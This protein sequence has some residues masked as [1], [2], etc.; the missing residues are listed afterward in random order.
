MIIKTFSIF[1][2]GRYYNQFCDGNS[3]VVSSLAAYFQTF[4]KSLENI[5]KFTVFGNV[6]QH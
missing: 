2:V 1:S 4:S 5:M 3:Y 6:T